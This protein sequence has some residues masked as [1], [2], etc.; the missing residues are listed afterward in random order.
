MMRKHL[1]FDEE[2]LLNC[3]KNILLLL[4]L[5]LSSCTNL[6]SN[7]GGDMTNY[8]FI[9]DWQGD[10]VD[11]EGN[12]FIF[13]ARVTHPDDNRYR[14]LI[15]SELDT[16]D[17]PLHVMDGVL[18][19]NRFSYTADEG[20]YEGSG[21]LSKDLFEGYYKGPVVGKLKMWRIKNDG[22]TV[23]RRQNSE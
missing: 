18:E 13:F 9:G 8:Q 5:F 6:N 17:E 10:G 1:P 3:K 2:A 21:T 20:L 15:L 11:S 23:D 4:C 14:I 7:S 12:G 16:L 19:N 22:E